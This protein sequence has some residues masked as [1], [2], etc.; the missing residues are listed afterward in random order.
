MENPPTSLLKALER[1]EFELQAITYVTGINVSYSNGEISY[2]SWD[3][4]H[5]HHL[6]FKNNEGWRCYGTPF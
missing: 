3:E 4:P 5:G 1:F 2:I 6:A